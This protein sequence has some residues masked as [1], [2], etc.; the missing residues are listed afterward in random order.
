[1]SLRRFSGGLS[2][3]WKPLAFLFAV[4]FLLI[5]PGCS[6]TDHSPTS[7]LAGDSLR[8]TSITPASGS[9]VAPGER[10]R[11]EGMLH[12]RFDRANGGRLS[13]LILGVVGSTLAYL[14]AGELQALVGREGDIPIAL[15][16]TLPASSAGGKLT[17]RFQL[18]PEGAST[19]GAQTGADYDIA[20]GSTAQSRG[21]R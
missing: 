9:T 19:Q 18:V 17:I 7:P 2:S 1:M 21:R 12:Y 6:D 4:G 15:G 5:A 16:F 10:L 20:P 8:L 14:D 13:V 11:F 3:P